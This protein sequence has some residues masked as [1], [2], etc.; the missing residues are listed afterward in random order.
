[1]SRNIQSI[2]VQPFAISFNAKGVAQSIYDIRDGE[3]W[4]DN[5]KTEAARCKWTLVF[6]DKDLGVSEAGV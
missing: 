5:A 2:E 4:R 3:D 1:M 6:F